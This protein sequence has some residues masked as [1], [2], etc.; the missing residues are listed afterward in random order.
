MTEVGSASWAEQLYR[1]FGIRPI[2]GGSGEGAGGTGGA[3]GA[4]GEGAGAGAVGAGGAGG[5]SGS[6][7]GEGEGDE[8][9][10]LKTALQ[11]ER[12]RAKD[13]EKQLKA[14]SKRLA[15][16]ENAGKPETERQAAEAEA[17]K[18]A[19]GE[20]TTKLRTANG[21]A[22]VMAAA[23][24]AG[25]SDAGLVYDMLAGRIEY[26]DEHEAT[27]TAAL[28]ADAKRRAPQLFGGAAGG[29][30]NSDAGAGAGRG[31]RGGG[32]AGGD[33]DM[34]RRLRRATGRRG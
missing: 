11:A 30:G 18:Q 6:G 5:E 1:E 7:A 33:D 3:G 4:G 13:F 20:V 12:N 27:N 26:S 29:G 31:E 21:K 16:L 2:S 32:G 8:A 17:A 10:A 34:N 19:L 22:A 24:T 23:A 25:A 15:E 28:V 9:T 14:T